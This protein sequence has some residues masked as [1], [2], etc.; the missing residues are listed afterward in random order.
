MSN[1]LERYIKKAA[2]ENG[3]AFRKEDPAMGF[4]TLLDTLLDDQRNAFSEHQKQ[5]LVNLAEKMEDVL[6]RISQEQRE[7][8]ERAVNAVAEYAKGILPK[9]LTA[10]TNEA[11][12]TAKAE[13]SG[14]LLEFDSTVVAFKRRVRICTTIITASAA[15]VLLAAVVMAYAA[16]RM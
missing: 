9:A 3:I 6:L 14:L 10:G 1:D 2:I 7:N 8:T 13:L 12:K 4:V 15:V 5:L 16:M 11:V